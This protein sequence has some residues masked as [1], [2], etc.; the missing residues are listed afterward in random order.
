MKS[1]PVKSP[2]GEERR[3]AIEAA[4][5][6]MLL[7]QGYA[8]VSL[9]KIASQLGMSVGNLQYYFATKDDLVE[10]VIL[11]ETQ[12][13]IE[14]LGGVLWN[15]DDLEA[16]V[17]HAV[18]SLMQYYA[19]D[20]GRFYAI[21]EALALHDPR[22]A[23]I[24]ADGYAYVFS[25]IEQLI[26]VMSPD[27]PLRRRTGLAQVLVALIDGASLQVQFARGSARGDGLA[28]LIDDVSKAIQHLLKIWE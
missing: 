27:L 2:K 28:A 16:N 22:Y 6:Q 10:A 12:K 18:G 23:K 11:G 17:D 3:E 8:G 24:K 20:A 15:P 7:D 5:R 4:A 14:L 19:S 21:M 26:A 9:R 25:Q 13:P 1:E